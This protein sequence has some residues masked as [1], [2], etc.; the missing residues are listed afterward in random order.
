MII[1]FDKFEIALSVLFYGFVRI[2]KP[3]KYGSLKQMC[4]VVSFM[5]G[6]Y[7]GEYLL[8]FKQRGYH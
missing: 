5:K 6:R 7:S 1:H 4:A 2:A 8:R 3:A